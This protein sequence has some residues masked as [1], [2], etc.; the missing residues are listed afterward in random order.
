MRLSRI[1]LR[2]IGKNGTRCAT[3]L[4]TRHESV[5]SV[6]FECRQRV[7]VARRSERRWLAVFGICTAP[8]MVS[9]VPAPALPLIV[10]IGVRL[11]WWYNDERLSSSQNDES[12]CATPQGRLVGR[13]GLFPLDTE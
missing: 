6:S 7:R 5:V 4:S 3:M 10:L 8:L 9:G 2:R 13:S 1:A 12:R 11:V